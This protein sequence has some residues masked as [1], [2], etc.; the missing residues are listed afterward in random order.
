MK[1]HVVSPALYIGNRHRTRGIHQDEIAGGELYK[2]PIVINGGAAL[3]LKDHGV[4]L[5]TIE[6]SVTP[7]TIYPVNIAGRIDGTKSIDIE[8]VK[9]A[10]ETIRIDPRQVV[11]TNP[12]QQRPPFLAGQSTRGSIHF[13][14]GH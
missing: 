3:K 4:T 8:A 14:G 13:H 1:S 10:L 11:C 12:G 5:D 7:R 9:P 6:P 2:A